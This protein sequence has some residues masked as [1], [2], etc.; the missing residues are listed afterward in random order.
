VPQNP[1]LLKKTKTKE[2]KT[3]LRTAASCNPCTEEVETGEP[4]GLGGQPV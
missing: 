2:N 1:D 4:M 3:K